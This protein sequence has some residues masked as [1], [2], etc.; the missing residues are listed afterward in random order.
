[1]ARPNILLITTDQQNAEIMGCAGNPVVQ[2]PHL[3]RLAREGVFFA[4][5]YTPHPVCTPARTSIF[6]G[7]TAKHH[8]VHY[9]INLR[10]DR[11]DPPHWTGLAA[12][13]TPFP[14]MLRREGYRT[15]LFG[16]LHTK[17][18]GDRNFG[19]ETM[20]LAEGKGQFVEF[21]TAPD[22]YRRYLQERGYPDSAW[23]TWEEPGYFDRGFTPSPLPVEDYIDTWTA[24]EAL[25]WLDEDDEKPFFAWVS[26]SGPHT[27]W[28]PPAPYDR[29]YDP[30][31][32]PEPARREGELEEK[33]PDWVDCIAQT[34]PATPPFSRDNSR[35]PGIQNAYARFS[36]RQRREMLA[37]YYGQITLIDAQIGRLLG[38][39]DERG[40]ADNT[41]VIFTTDHGDYLGNNWAFF[42]YGA[43]Y[44]SLSR[45]PFLMRWPGHMPAGSECRRMVS[46]IDIAPTICEAVEV[47]PV[48]PMDG[49]SILPLLAD[50]GVPW[51]DHLV[52]DGK[53]R[54][55]ANAK[56]KYLLWPDGFAEL[57]DRES[58]PHELHNRIDD[59]DLA[60]TREAMH[61]MLHA[62]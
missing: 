33:H 53:P 38:D 16:K 35:E 49:Q 15:A 48:D 27:P 42:K 39:L 25:R 32:I 47:D 8:G 43:Q 45:I 23:R 7:Q 37:A 46:L 18:A 28:D 58:D 4:E 59:A 26:F 17:Q 13:A 22:D 52:F 56:W 5:A 10:E 54:C 20:R 2:T 60:G 21:G 11:A 51:R 9:N 34:V 40:L 29:M 30:D 19:V 31:E 1:M 44:D 57:Y 24:T 62:T 50:D 36:E 3:D 12:D 61:A 14:E 6:T 41:L 55:V